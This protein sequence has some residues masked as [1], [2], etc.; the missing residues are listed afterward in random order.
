MGIVSAVAMFLQRQPWAKHAD[1]EDALES[2]SYKSRILPRK[3]RFLAVMTGCVVGIALM[4]YTWRS[5]SAIPLILGAVLQPRV[6]RMG[7]LL[8]SV[9]AP[10]LSAWV[11]P[12]GVIMLVGTVRG[13]PFP[14][15]FLGVSLTLAWILSPILLLW[16]DATLVAEAVKER[17]TR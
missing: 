4:S 8:L 6:P 13:D 15:D 5:L 16:C 2:V 9:A 11:V 10:L 17:R 14:H 12:L 7:R 1:E 3:L